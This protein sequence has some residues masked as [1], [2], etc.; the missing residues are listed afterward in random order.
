MAHG[1][2][3][4]RARDTG[5]PVDGAQIEVADPDEEFCMVVLGLEGS[6]GAGGP[7]TGH[8][9]DAQGRQGSET[10]LVTLRIGDC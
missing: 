3:V 8:Y 6:R 10:V 7:L 4:R 1:G 5:Q 2:D 9:T